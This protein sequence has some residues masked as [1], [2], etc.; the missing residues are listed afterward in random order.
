MKKDDPQLGVSD[1]GSMRTGKSDAQIPHGDGRSL[2]SEP[3]HGVAKEDGRRAKDTQ[4]AAKDALRKLG[5][6]TPKK[7]S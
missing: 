6:I 1:S 7:S 4:T 5:K 3:T 2:S